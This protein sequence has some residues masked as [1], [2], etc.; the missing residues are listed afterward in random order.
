M[1]LIADSGSTKTEWSL[2]ENFEDIRTQVTSGINPF[3][4]D[5]STIIAV[6]NKELL[7]EKDNIDAIY[8]YGAGCNN[9]EKTKL[10]KDALVTV[11]DCTN[12]SVASDLLGAARSLCQH[13][14][15]IACILGTGS[16]SCY[17]DGVEIVNHVSPLG[18][19]L[20][21]E[22]SGAV[23]G[24]KLISDILKNQLPKDLAE[25]FWE[26]YPT[27]PTEILNNIYRN[28]FPNR[29]LASF[30]KFLAEN[31]TNTSIENIVIEEFTNFIT[32]N[33]LQY[34]MIYTS[35][36]NFSGSI[37]FYFSDQLKKAL[38]RN[39][40]QLGTIVKSP[41]QGLISYHI[42]KVIF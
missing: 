40:L 41:M 17:Y 16:N 36:V 9:P 21:D 32:R 33:L 30:T 19:I 24:K 31:I 42:R 8:F 12:I 3:F 15:G 39:N 20:G 22:G 11:F 4:H 14:A 5:T 37:A 28:P 10:V 18:Y 6:L 1:I 23:L 13:K 2:L 25:K 35:E 29:Y 38:E 34:P 26:S 7:L 27:P